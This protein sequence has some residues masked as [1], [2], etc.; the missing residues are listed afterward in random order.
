MGGCLSC[1]G[2]IPITPSPHPLPDPP[3]EEEEEEDEDEGP[4]YYSFPE[5]FASSPTH[6]LGGMRFERELGKGAM[7][8]V[9]LAVSEATNQQYA[10]KIYNNA[11]LYKPVLSPEEP[12][13][14]QVQREVNLM[15]T[16]AHPY[17]LPIH[18]VIWSKPT[19]S[20]FL[21][22]P[23]A[24][25]GSLQSL[26]DSKSIGPSEFPICFYQVAEAFRYLHEQNIVHRDLKPDNVLCYEPGWFVLSD[27]SVSTQLDPD[28]PKLD[29][30]KGS[31]AFLS[32]EECSG[33]PYDPKAADVWAFGVCIYR[34]VFGFFPFNIESAHGRAV[35]ATIIMVKELLENEVLVIPDLPEGVD[36]SVVEVLQTTMEKKV[37]DRP[38]FEQVVTFEYFAPGRE[39]HERLRQKALESQNAE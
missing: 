25:R 9:Y 26:L 16:I 35:V 37:E 36:P 4:F 5:F 1:K 34:S 27:F 31:P 11:H 12:L 6:Q 15:G 7:S 20:T 32:P 18:D 13:Y 2:S 30:T 19:N 8:R 14:Q 33:D 28:D 21:L 10:V 22:L 24:E 29:D 38:T 17:I 39:A 3:P 23:F